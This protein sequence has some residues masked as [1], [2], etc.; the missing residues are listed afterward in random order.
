M[1]NNYFLK[2][3][4]NGD[5]MEIKDIMSKNLIVK[6]INTNIYEIAKTMKE[7][8]IGFIP[9]SKNNTIIGVLTDRDIVTKILAN[10]D[11]KIDGYINNKI[12]TIN[13][14]KSIDDI[15]NLM[16]NKKI[17]RV[18]IENNNKIVGV[19]SLSDII[20]Y[21]DDQKIKNAISKIWEIDKN[22]DRKN[23]SINDFEL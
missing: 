11:N 6:D 5:N 14:N 23:V 3:I 21:I 2:N 12:I 10:N 19:V 17:K 20:K 8:D 7:Y 1:Y 13:I 9:I 18:L 16:G 4:I 15:I 22:I